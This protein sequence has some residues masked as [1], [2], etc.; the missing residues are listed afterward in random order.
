MTAEGP[1]RTGQITWN[2]QAATIFLPYDAGV[3]GQGRVWLL[4]GSA[5]DDLRYVM[6]S[7]DSR[8]L[9]HL[10]YPQRSPRVIGLDA[11]GR[12]YIC[13]SDRATVPECLVI[14]EGMEEPIWQLGLERG[15]GIVTGGALTPGQLYVTTENGYFIAVGEP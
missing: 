6:L 4:Y 5:W 15:A 13:G 11:A 9:L 3:S 7:P 10:R 2:W 8:L 14:S 1:R 12:A